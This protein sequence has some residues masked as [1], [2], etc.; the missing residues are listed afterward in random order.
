MGLDIR[1]PLGLVFQILGGIIALFGLF[2]REDVAL[3]EK[4]LGL[5][6]NL[7]WGAVIF[8]FGAVMFFMGRR[9]KWQYD[10]FNTE[11]WETQAAIKPRH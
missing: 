7:V 2:T 3:Y 10:P 11:P 5:N 6:L 9:Q 8:L 4:S 1:I